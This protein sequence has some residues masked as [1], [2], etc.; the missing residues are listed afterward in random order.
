MK[1]RY[2]VLLFVI[3]VIAAII[4]ILISRGCSKSNNTEI[5]QTTTATSLTTSHPTI[6]V[7][8]TPILANTTTTSTPTS[9]HTTI[10]TVTTTTA[11]IVP[12][13]MPKVGSNWV[14]TVTYSDPTHN[15]NNTV[16]QT[17]TLED[18]NSI[19]EQPTGST[20]TP[21]NAACFKLHVNYGNADR[22][23][24]S[25]METIWQS[26]DGWFSR[27]NSVL[28]YGVL[29]LSYEGTTY[30]SVS[31]V[32]NVK[33]TAGT[34]IGIPFSIGSNWTYDETDATIYVP[35]SLSYSN[36]TNIVEADHQ[37]V[38]TADGKTTFTDC[39]KISTYDTQ[40]HT[41]L[42]TDYYSPTVMRTVKE[43]DYSFSGTQ[44]MVLVSYTL[45]K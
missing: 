13:E 40:D 35:D 45:V 11:T 33:L 2:I 41:L 26:A 17:F 44:T 25:G 27:D 9:L 10:P 29:K 30:T 4:I 31:Q 21:P 37:S 16:T 42:W 28:L 22:Y 7:S 20:L 43:I 39:V 14:Y 38:T 32:R 3:L 6:I 18:L 15:C 24:K 23:S 12:T 19:P 8:I 5:S 34:N 1:R 36:N